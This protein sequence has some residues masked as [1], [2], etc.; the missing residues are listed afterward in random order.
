M[1]TARVKR[2]WC[3]EVFQQGVSRGAGVKRSSQA[4]A[5]VTARVVLASPLGV[6]ERARSVL[7][8]RQ[9]T[10]VLLI[11]RNQRPVQVITRDWQH[12]VGG[13]DGGGVVDEQGHDFDLV[14]QV[15]LKWAQAGTL[16]RQPFRHNVPTGH[17][18][19]GGANNEVD[20]A[21]HLV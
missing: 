20:A 9:V 3:K 16:G 12:N 19:D 11:H 21:T 4:G 1:E 8:P 13:T 2:S 17:G 14:D 7:K 18:V 5:R 15:A 6:N 10:R